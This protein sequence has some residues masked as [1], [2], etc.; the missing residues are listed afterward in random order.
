MYTLGLTGQMGA[1]KTFCAPIFADFG[2]D[3]LDT[4]DVSRM[5][6]EAGMPCTRELEDRFGGE[7]IR[8]DGSLDRRKLAQIAFS[9]TVNTAALNFITHKYILAECRA[10]IDERRNAGAFACIIAAP[11]LFESRFN[12]YCDFTAA[13]LCSEGTRLERV[14]ERDNTTRSAALDRMRRQHD[15]AFFR[16]SC[17]FLI[18]NNDGFRPDLQIDLI[19]QQLKF[20]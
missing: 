1:G 12:F 18:N 9:D 15:E 2:I 16:R 8:A 14:I 11:L 10:F 13:V 20:V 4:D 7:I 17:D 5:V 6:C 3:T 19:V